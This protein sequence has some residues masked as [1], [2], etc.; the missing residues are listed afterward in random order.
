MHTGEQWGLGPPWNARPSSP[1]PRGGGRGLGL[2]H[3]PTC[4]M[5][6]GA[7][8]GSRQLSTTGRGPGCLPTT[9]AAARQPS[10]HVSQRKLVQGVFSLRLLFLSLPLPPRSYKTRKIDLC[11]K[12]RR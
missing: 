1:A 11:L 3:L 10:N 8:G 2:S 6:E 9:G 7:S 5:Q 4:P 12:Q